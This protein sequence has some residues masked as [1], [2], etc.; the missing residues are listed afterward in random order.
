MLKVQEKGKAKCISPL[1]T[2][3]VAYYVCPRNF[4]TNEGETLNTRSCH[5]YVTWAT[6]IPF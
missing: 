4:S 5:K 1:A 3:C 6:Q 2:I